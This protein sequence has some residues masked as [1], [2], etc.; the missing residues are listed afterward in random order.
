MGGRA[1]PQEKQR[2][3]MIMLSTPSVGSRACVSV[4]LE[5]REG[6][7]RSWEQ[8]SQSGRVRQR[9]TLQTQT[10]VARGKLPQKKF[11]RRDE[12]PAIHETEKAS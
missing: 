12:A 10:Q 7:D 5:V 3:G 2:T 11:R 8:L 9:C 6:M 1:L 4:S